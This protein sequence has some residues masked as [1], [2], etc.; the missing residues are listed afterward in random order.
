LTRNRT[1][2]SATAIVLA[3]V[4]VGCN[5]QGSSGGSE[6]ATGAVKIDGSSTVFPIT[7]A[8]AEEFKA[9]EPDVDVRVGQSG[10][11]GGFEK[12]CR[13]E[14]DIADAS[15]AIEE[16]EQAACQQEGVEWVELKTAL[17][18]ISVA[19]NTENDFADCLT[20][21]ELKEIWEPDSTVRTWNDVRDD[22][23]DE[24]IT[25]YGPG[26][27]SGTFDFFTAEIVGEESAS[28]SD[29]TQSEDDN[30]LVQGVKGDA[31]SL[32]YFGFAY[33]EANLDSIRPVAIDGGDGCVR[34]TDETIKDGS[35]TPLSRPLYIY[36]STEALAKEHV[37]AFTEF[38]LDTVN[39]ILADVKYVALPDEE[40]QA[41][42]AALDN[43]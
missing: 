41:A 12:F 20:V 33:L 1:L 24:E 2:A 36:P 22:W 25:L 16:D 26:S 28:R 42:K 21:E 5:T 13:G 37:M 17:D 7:E 8:I 32:G 19:V 11:G 40:L 15:R 14:I 3:L 38:Y 35:Y 18:G 31:N 27:D 4:A 9:A 39:A 34:P 29:Y 10:T 43:V 6:G 30:V 23:P